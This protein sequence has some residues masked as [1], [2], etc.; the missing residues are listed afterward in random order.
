MEL[1]L[2]AA[3]AKNRIIGREGKIPWN[4]LPEDMKHFRDL[5]MGYPVIMGRKTYESIPWKFRP[6]VGRKNIVLTNNLDFTAP[7]EVAL[8]SSMEQTFYEASKKNNRAYI[9]GGQ[10]VYEQTIDMASKLEITEINKEYAGDAYFPEIK[11]DIWK[12][13]A[14][15]RRADYSFVSYVK[16]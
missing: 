9:I 5:T 14:R 10:K 13:T 7:S 16:K 8:C 2:I 6:L 15:D 11:E 3:V 1:I 12:E 4:P